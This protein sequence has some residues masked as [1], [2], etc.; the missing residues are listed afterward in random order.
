MTNGEGGDAHRTSG[1]PVYPLDA[2]RCSGHRW[3]QCVWHNAEE[4]NANAR[5]LLRI[6]DGEQPSRSNKVR[7]KLGCLGGSLL[8]DYLL[9]TRSLNVLRRAE[10][11]PDAPQLN[12]R[13]TAQ[14]SDLGGEITWQD[15]VATESGIYLN[16]D[17]ER[18][19]PREIGT[20]QLA[21]HCW[22]RC[23]HA[24]AR[25]GG[26]AQVRRGNAPEGA[27]RASDPGIAQLLRLIK[28]GNKYRSRA[29]LK[30]GTGDRHGAQAIRVG[31]QHH[32]K[33]A[34]SWK[35]PLQGAHIRCDRIEPHLYPGI[36][37]ERW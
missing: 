24:N 33:V 10:M 19:K 32:I 5:N 27:N 26:V 20:H 18:G 9:Q 25:G 8:K 16:V 22:R 34:A 2:D 1:E 4:R 21:N 35:L 31:L 15:A 23:G 11:A 36:T 14:R 28:C 6:A 3:A 37:P 7:F 13:V 17:T 30:C 12:I 29:S